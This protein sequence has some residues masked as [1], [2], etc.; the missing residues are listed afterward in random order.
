MTVYR[1]VRQFR[2]VRED[3]LKLTQSDLAAA[4]GCSRQHVSRVE[5]GLSEYSHSQLKRLS[6]LSGLPVGYFFDESPVKVPGWWRAYSGLPLNVRLR[7]DAV[8]GGVVALAR[9]APMVGV[10]V[11]V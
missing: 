3:V 2:D 4:L 10:P 7:A 1:H 8:L 11:G 5:R 6:D 9:P